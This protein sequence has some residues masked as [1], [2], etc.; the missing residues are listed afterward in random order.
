M[1]QAH[2]QLSLYGKK[3]FEKA[4]L[5]PP[6]RLLAQMPNEACFYYVVRGSARVFTPT[7]NISTDTDEGLVLQCGNY[8]N[9]YIQ[10]QEDEYCEA[11]AVHFYP[12]ML[13]MIYDKEFPNFLLE[14]K[15]MKPLPFEKTKA[16]T[17]LKNYINSLQFYFDNPELV[18]D[19]LLRIKMKELIILLA[20]TD[21][22]EAIQHL[23]ARL[24][25]KTEV[26]FK[27]VIEANVFNNLNLEELAAL[28]HLSLSSF[29]REFARHYDCPPAKYMKQRKLEQASRLLLGTKLRISDIAYDC[30]FADL[31][32]FSKS[33][34]K[35]YG[36]S[37]SEY[38]LN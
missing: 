23:I 10:T 13:K 5:K 29:K 9:E 24:F 11:I 18:S 4:I 8:F 21:N 16:S 15:E 31:A 12:E 34:Q 30:G 1:I 19:E 7:G 35:A 25:T 2:Q 28:T 22:A 17:L 14:V 20:K 3:T 32:H 38:R 27:E 6:F 36:C 26:D 37:P 33:F